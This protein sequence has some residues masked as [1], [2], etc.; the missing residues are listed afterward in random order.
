[1]RE[2]ANCNMHWASDIGARW[3]TVMH[4]SVSWPFHGEYHCRTCGR[5]Y[6]VPWAVE[7]FAP[8]PPTQRSSASFRVALLPLVIVLAILSALVARAA[9]TSMLQANDPAAM[10]FARYIAALDGMRPANLEASEIDSTAPSRLLPIGNP[11]YHQAETAGDANASRQ[12]GAAKIPVSGFAITP[13][14]YKFRYKG[15][16]TSGNNVAYIFQITPRNKREGL[17]K[18]ELWVDGET[19][20]AVHQPGR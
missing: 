18:G 11:Q 16:V 1:M 3:C 8:A 2:R 12:V 5:T 9:D 15:A 14:N 17:I 20:A 7:T 10:A 13:A 19:G 4:D 6:P